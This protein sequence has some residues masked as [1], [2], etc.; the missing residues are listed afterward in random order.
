VILMDNR[1]V[2]IALVMAVSVCATA[3]AFF[4]SIP[5]AVAAR[6]RSR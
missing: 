1:A 2:R 3:F 4:V 5:F 6:W